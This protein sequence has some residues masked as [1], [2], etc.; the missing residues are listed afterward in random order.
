MKNDVRYV[1]GAWAFS[2]ELLLKLKEAIFDLFFDV[3][4]QFPL[5]AEQLALSVFEV[6]ITL[7]KCV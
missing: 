5:G 1:Y 7:S 6:L 3:Q 4:R 2:S